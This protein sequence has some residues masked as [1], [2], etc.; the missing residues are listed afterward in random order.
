MKFISIVAL[1]GI[2]STSLMAGTCL[3]EDPGPIQRK[4]KW[5]KSY[6]SLRNGKLY[7]IKKFKDKYKVDSKSKILNFGDNKLLHTMMIRKGSNHRTDHS[8][9]KIVK[10]QIEVK[11]SDE[12][13]IGND[14]EVECRDELSGIESIKVKKYVREN[15]T[16]K[17]EKFQKVTEINMT[18]LSCLY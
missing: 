9:L 11:S 4:S 10:Y 1:F 7:F 2:I 18:D 6:I 13:Q 14:V 5:E 12:C 17:L 3:I 15:K 16:R 8:L